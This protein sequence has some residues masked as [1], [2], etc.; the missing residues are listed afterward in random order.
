MKIVPNL[1]LLKSS[2]VVDHEDKVPLSHRFTLFIAEKNLP[3]SSQPSCVSSFNQKWCP[4]RK[5]A[6]DFIHNTNNWISAFLHNSQ[7]TQ[8]TGECF[9]CR[10]RHDTEFCVQGSRFS[11]SSCDKVNLAFDCEHLAMGS[12]SHLARCHCLDLHSESSSFI[13]WGFSTIRPHV[14][15]GRKAQNFLALL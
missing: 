6:P 14:S 10:L 11:E 8:C 4:M 5:R 15:T 3:C 1:I 9:L 7:C 12:N 13:C 2:N